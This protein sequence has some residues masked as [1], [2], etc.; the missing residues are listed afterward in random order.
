VVGEPG[1][2]KSRL[3]WEFTHSHRT[4]GCLLL[5]ADSVSYGKATTYVPVTP[6]DG[7]VLDVIQDDDP[8]LPGEPDLPLKNPR[9]GELAG[10]LGMVR[11]DHPANL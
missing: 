2:G 7:R 3:F 6:G 11:I 1:V 10:C 5:E 8:N 4:H 9:E